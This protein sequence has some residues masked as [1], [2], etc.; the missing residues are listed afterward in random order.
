MANKRS[1]QRGKERI[2]I[3]VQ[4]KN[5]KLKIKNQ[6]ASRGSRGR[7]TK[8]APYQSK[9]APIARVAPNRKWFS[10]TRMISQDSL[11]TSCAAVAETQKDPYVCLLKRSKLPIGLIKGE[12]Q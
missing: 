12:L 8:A 7:I 5:S 6:K 3:I 10:Y 1:I 9:D 4:R 11:A 2:S